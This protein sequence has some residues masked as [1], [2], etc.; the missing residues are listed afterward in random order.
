MDHK[1]CWVP[2][3]I[4][5]EYSLEALMLKLKL[6]NLG[7]LMGTAASLEKPLMLGNKASITQEKK[8]VTEDEMLRWHH[9]LSGHETEQTLGDSGGT[10][11]PG[12]LQSMG[13]QRVERDLR[14]EQ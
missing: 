11:E 5:P 13:L 10:E 4:N 7:H 9:G 3:K 2:K 12:V 14:I 6:Q 8:E 1:E